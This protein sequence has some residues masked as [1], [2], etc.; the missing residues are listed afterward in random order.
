MP[1]GT[2]TVTYSIYDSKGKLLHTETK[3]FTLPLPGSDDLD[4]EFL[5]DKKFAGNGFV[6]ERV[7][8]TGPDDYKK[9]WTNKFNIESGSGIYPKPSGIFAKEKK[10]VK[11]TISFS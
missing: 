8:I 4:M 3:T 2:Y 10:Q 7:T 5:E 11:S 1:A 9:T 6:M